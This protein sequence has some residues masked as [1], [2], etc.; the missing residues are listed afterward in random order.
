MCQILGLNSNTPITVNFSFIGFAARGGRTGEHC[1]G[2]GIAFQDDVECRLFIDDGK[3]SE[4]PLAEFLCSHPIKSRSVLAHIR[5]AT[6]G[7][8]TLS[9]CH[10]FQREW[11]GRSWVF[12]HNGDLLDFAPRLGGDYLPLGSTDSER[13]FCF[14]L[15]A[16][17]CKTCASISR[18]IARRRGGRLHRSWLD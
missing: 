6:Q 2:W 16:A 18:A 17:C 8:V 10:P 1:D 7:A 15:P 9:N 4:S 12:C 11:L 5:K 13:A 14:L 3:A